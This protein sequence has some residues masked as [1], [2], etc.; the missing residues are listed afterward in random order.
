ME[1]GRRK[2]K[3]GKCEGET[4]GPHKGGEAFT[5]I[6]ASGEKNAS[7]LLIGKGRRNPVV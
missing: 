3:K 7:V 5:Y 6:G 4:S 2:R 1:K